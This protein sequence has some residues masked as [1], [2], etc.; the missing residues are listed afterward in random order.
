MRNIKI[1]RF[2]PDKDEQCNPANDLDTV[3]P[4]THEE[5][6]QHLRS[7]IRTFVLPHM[8]PRWIQFLIENRNR[9]N[10]DQSG[11]DSRKA[12]RKAD[13]VLRSFPLH[14][15]SCKQLRNADKVSET[16]PMNFS[17]HHWVYFELRTPPCKVT[18]VEA[19]ARFVLRA[20][21]AILSIREGEFA[22]IFCHDGGIWH[23]IKT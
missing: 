22:V 19:E 5:M 11:P 17:K 1:N 7:F 3:I 8:Q 15:R 9:W 20:D 12:L 13:E 23:C 18:V 4:C 2:S 16:G 21:S 14:C 6:E 10:K